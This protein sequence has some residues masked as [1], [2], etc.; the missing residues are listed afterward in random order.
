MMTISPKGEV[1][2]CS[3]DFYYTILMGNIEQQSLSEIWKSE[4]FNSIREKLI[5]G[6]R[7]CTPAC[8]KCDYRGFT[9][10]MLAEHGLNKTSRIKKAIKKYLN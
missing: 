6:E 9:Y 10:E 5:R 1:S 2:V 3:E 7:S 4:K 8:S